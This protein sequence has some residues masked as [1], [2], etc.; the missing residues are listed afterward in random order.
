MASEHKRTIMN[1]E[2]IDFAL[3]RMAQQIIESNSGVDNIAL[4][5]IAD[6]GIPITDR[7][8]KYLSGNSKNGIKVG[9][10]DITLYRDDLTINDQPELKETKIDFD[11]DG[12][13]I[14]LVDDV[15][16]TGRTARAA[17]SALLEYGRPDRIQ[18]AVLVDRGH[19]E[20]PIQADFVGRNLDTEKDQRVNVW[21]SEK[22]NNKKD[23]VVLITDIN[24]QED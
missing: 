3:R 6:G 21:V 18:L 7:L 8:H 22:P 1:E 11:I 19:R 15:L 16:F 2:R 14:V 4:V 12:M 9:M 5:G 13:N 20:I 17:I 10:I 24:N 23:K